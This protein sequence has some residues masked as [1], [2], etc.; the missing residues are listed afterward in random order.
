MSRRRAAEIP[1][2]SLIT[3]LLLGSSMRASQRAEKDGWSAR[4]NY[5]ARALQIQRGWHAHLWSP[6]VPSSRKARAV[7]H[8]GRG[9]SS[10]V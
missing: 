10:L 1:P 3:V 2:G 4:R 7:M 6:Y 5:A 8:S 9:A